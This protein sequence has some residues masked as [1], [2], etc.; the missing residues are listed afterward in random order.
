MK[1]AGMPMPTPKPRF[2]EELLS[3]SSKL[4]LS[5]LSVGLGAGQSPASV[6]DV[7][8]M[9]VNVEAVWLVKLAEEVTVLAEPV[10][11]AIG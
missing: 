3:G 5:V 1:K 11:V 2:N 9:V 4:S 10:D 6:V 7:A 8:A